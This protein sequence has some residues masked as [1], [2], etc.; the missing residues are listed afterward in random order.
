LEQVLASQIVV[1]LDGTDLSERAIPVARDIAERGGG[2]LR[3]VRVH[4]PPRIPATSHHVL[5]PRVGGQLKRERADALKRE[6]RYL[7]Q[8]A[9]DA[10][11]EADDHAPPVS[12]AL[13]RG[14]VEHSVVDDVRRSDATLVVLSA[15][16]PGRDVPDQVDR[17]TDKVVRQCPTPVLVVRSRN[18]LDGLAPKGLR[19]IL[20]P[21]DGSERSNSVLEPARELAGL[22]GAS[23]TLLTVVPKESQVGR[24]TAARKQLKALADGLRREGVEADTRLEHGHPPTVILA[25]AGEHDT[26]VI[27]MASRCRG[28]LTRM[29]L[30]SVSDEVLRRAEASVLVV[31]PTA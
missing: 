9:H 22:F 20:V 27:A 28:P 2:S 29:V 12:A 16:V 4:I 14:P 24:A 13:L 15:P 21:I 25:V 8:A 19:H 1:P 23:M 3:L 17:V 11:P 30:G 26:D 7:D 31:S 10:A 18:G 5:G 6:Q